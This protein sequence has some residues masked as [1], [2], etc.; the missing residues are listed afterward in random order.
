MSRDK[1]SVNNLTEDK[2]EGDNSTAIKQIQ[3]PSYH[4]YVPQ[5]KKHESIMFKH[6]VK[7]TQ[8]NYHKH[9]KLFISNTHIQSST[10][11]NKLQRDLNNW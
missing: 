9:N 7:R 10:V 8:E 3:K 1:L 11:Q 5:F 6:R 2:D 4:Q